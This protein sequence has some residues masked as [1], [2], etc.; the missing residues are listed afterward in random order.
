MTPMRRRRTSHDPKKPSGTSAA[1][2]VP[3][4]AAEL[5][6]PP[7]PREPAA[8]PLVDVLGEGVV[9]ALGS[10]LVGVGV[11]VAPGST[12][13]LGEIVALGVGVV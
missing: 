10:E 8:W 3:T 2:V 5:P 4:T 13:W 7:E 12:L 9:S 1:R 11:S 6:P